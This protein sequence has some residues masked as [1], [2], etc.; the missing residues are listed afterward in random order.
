MDFIRPKITKILYQD[1][2]IFRDVTDNAKLH[3]NQIY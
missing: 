2:N 3:R 1:Q